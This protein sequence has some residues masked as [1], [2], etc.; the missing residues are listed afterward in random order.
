MPGSDELPRERGRVRGR[1]GNRDSDASHSEMLSG[2]SD[3]AGLQEKHHLDWQE[4][5][6]TGMKYLTAPGTDIN[7]FDASIDK[8]AHL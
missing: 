3:P 2:F 6:Q 5:F 4:S 1:K 7:L 8:K